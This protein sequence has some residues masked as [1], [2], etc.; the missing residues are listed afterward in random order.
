[1]KLGGWRCWCLCL[2][3]MPPKRSA[4]DGWAKI[5]RCFSFGGICSLKFSVDWDESS[6]GDFGL[7]NRTSAFHLLALLCR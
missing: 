6:T 7:A 2:T 5:W 3:S 4:W 1:M